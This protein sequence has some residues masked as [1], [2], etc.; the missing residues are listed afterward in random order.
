MLPVGSSSDGQSLNDSTKPPGGADQTVCVRLRGLSK[1]FGETQATRGV[2]LDLL[3]HEVHALL[4]E[5]G[6]GKTTLMHM[7]AGIT[8]PDDGTIGIGGADA[9]LHNRRDGARLGIGIV[10]QHYGL[11][12]ELDGIENYLLGHPHAGIWLNH[13][14]ALAELRRIADEFGLDV[15]VDRPVGDLTIGERQRLEILIALTTGADILILDEPTAALGSADVEVLGHVLGHLTRQGK[16]VVYITHK[17]DEVFEFADRVTVMRRGE[18]VA[19]FKRDEL[20]RNELTEAL[21]GTLPPKTETKPGTAGSSAIALHGVTVETEA[22][23][24]GLADVSLIA[25]RGEVLGVAGVLGNGQEALT[26]L[27]TGI[28]APS[29]GTIDPKPDTVAYIPEDRAADGLAL[30]LP[31]TDNSIVHCHRDSTLRQMGALSL[32]R[33]RIYA[34]HLVA[35][36]NVL[37]ANVDATSATLSGGNQQ[38]LVVAR[39]FDRTPDL[40]VAHNPYRGL[41]VGATL[42]VRERLLAARDAD[43]AVVLISPDLEDLFDI[44]DRIVVLSDG[45]IIGEIDPHETTMQ[46]V[47]ALLGGVAA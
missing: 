24:R 6:A 26:Q 10:Q 3:T 44:A 23:R 15:D 40:I 22:H 30:S 33:I 9:R 32:R 16:C 8:Q 42:E 4:G 46:E 20:D 47:G 1:A 34:A 39:E 12:E 18:V 29:H 41:D 28:V 38:K 25:H 5:N 7:L 14:D 31:L 11:V 21:V 13:K 27:L 35:T 36:G 19:Q 17:L 37:T 2:N 45:Q 43:G